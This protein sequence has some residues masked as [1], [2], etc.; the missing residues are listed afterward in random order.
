M[1]QMPQARP[2]SSPAASMRHIVA[3]HP[4]TAFLVLLYAITAGS[5]SFRR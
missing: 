4:V 2:M 3:Q 5:R 1:T